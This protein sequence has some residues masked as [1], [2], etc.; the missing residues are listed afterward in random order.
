[1]LSA[2]RSINIVESCTQQPEIFQQCCPAFLI[3][4][5]TTLFNYWRG[6]LLSSRTHPAMCVLPCVLQYQGLLP[7]ALMPEL[8]AEVVGTGKTNHSRSCSSPLY[9]GDSPLIPPSHMYRIMEKGHSPTHQQV[10]TE[11]GL[12]SYSLLSECSW[13]YPGKEF[14]KY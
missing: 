2:F 3:N 8:E 14:S 1:M 7:A 11:T 6:P 12:S 9:F 13:T 5:A 4:R 10:S